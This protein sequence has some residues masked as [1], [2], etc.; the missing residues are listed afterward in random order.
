MLKRVSRVSRLRGSGSHKKPACVGERGGEAVYLMGTS[1][2]KP[3]G[4]CPT[5]DVNIRHQ[6]VNSHTVPPKKGS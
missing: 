3:D 4:D 1:P 2:N 6:S 5:H